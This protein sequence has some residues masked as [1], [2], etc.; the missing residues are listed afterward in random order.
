MLQ[1]KKIKGAVPYIIISLLALWFTSPI[2]HEIKNTG[3]NDWDIICYPE[4]LARITFI[5]YHQFPLWNSYSNG[6]RP[7][8]G[9]P[10]TSF[11]R[12]TFIF[13]LL[14]GCIVGLKVEFLVM[15]IMGMIG[16]FLLSQYYRITPAS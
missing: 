13:P 2:F 3:P 8:L 1:I 16:M 7:L 10:Q 14:F 15:C 11:L 4:E 9:H 12:P 5:D 6:G